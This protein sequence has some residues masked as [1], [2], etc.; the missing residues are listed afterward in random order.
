MNVDLAS[1]ALK[2]CSYLAVLQ[3]AG[4]ALFLLLFGRTLDAST[5]VIRRLGLACARALAAEGTIPEPEIH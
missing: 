5:Q 4:A 1:I 3:A 2:A